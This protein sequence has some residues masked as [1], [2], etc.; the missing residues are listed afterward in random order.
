MEM[1]EIIHNDKSPKDAVAAL[2]NRDKNYE[3]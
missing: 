2:M 1:Y 3:L